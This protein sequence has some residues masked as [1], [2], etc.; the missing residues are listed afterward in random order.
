MKSVYLLSFC[1]FSIFSQAASAAPLTVAWRNKPPYHY[2]EN[3][4]EQGFLLER[5]RQVFTAAGIEVQFV[6]EPAKRIWANFSSGTPSYCS[7]GW[8]RLPEREAIAQFSTIFHTDRPH[9]LLVAP[10]VLAQVRAHRTLTDLLNDARLTMGLLDGVSYGPDIDVMIRNARNRIERK[11]VDPAMLTRSVAANRV[12]FM[13]I[14]RDDWEYLS[15]RDAAMRDTAQVDFPDMPAGLH[16]YI[17]CSKDVSADLMA[18][19]NKAIATAASAR[20]T[21]A[22]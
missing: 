21:A 9:T 12:S 11:N 22:K 14:D 13:F 4:S 20:K 1:L 18:R 2:I 17:V 5:A 16:R 15:R 8:Y 10:A 3:G 7:I 19:L 6:E